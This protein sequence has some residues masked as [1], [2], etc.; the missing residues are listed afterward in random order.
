MMIDQD[1]ERMAEANFQDALDRIRREYEA[2]RYNLRFYQT[3]FRENVETA[4]LFQATLPSVGDALTDAYL[5][6]FTLE[7]KIP[8]QDDATQLD[9]RLEI[10]FAGNWGLDTGKLDL[11]TI[12]DEIRDLER[13]ACQRLTAKIH[14]MKLE[15]AKTQQATYQIN[16]K[17][18]RGPIQQGSENTQEIKISDETKS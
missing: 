13:K 11:N 3:D 15:A 17:E 6:A 7:E 8:S 12:E 18:N 4:R 9:H 1:S 2:Q 5:E 14:K 10:L 16:I